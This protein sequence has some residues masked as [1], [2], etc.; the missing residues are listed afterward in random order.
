M[1]FQ[2]IFQSDCVVCVGVYLYLT[3]AK[4]F[5]HFYAK[6]KHLNLKVTDNACINESCISDVA[7]SSQ[8]NEKL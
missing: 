8:F 7:E 4:K 1:S 3:F 2:L 5:S 6:I